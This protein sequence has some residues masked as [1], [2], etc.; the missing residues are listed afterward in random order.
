MG[1]ALGFA[2]VVGGVITAG[3]LAVA[4]AVSMRAATR[5]LSTAVVMDA[6][7]LSNRVPCHVVGSWEKPS[8]IITRVNR[9]AQLLNVRYRSVITGRV[10][11]S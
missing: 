6:I 9:V 1:L 7:V 10:A 11:T 4:G 5:T 8:A 3:E 2:S